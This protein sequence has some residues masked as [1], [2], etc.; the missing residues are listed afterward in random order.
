MREKTCCFT[1]HRELKEPLERLE[2]R[3][4]RTTETLIQEGYRYF[5]AGGARGFDALAA[6]VVLR[7]KERY[8]HIHLIMVLPFPEQYEYEFG[9]GNREIEE[10]HMLQAGASK[11]V[12]LQRGYSRGCYYARD[13][14]LVDQSSVCVAYQ[15]KQTGGTAYTTQYART[16]GVKVLWL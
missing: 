6:R 16:R 1:G 12:C 4:W 9:W 15:Y 5:G 3:V 11:V 8:P 10:Y 13:R 7:M 14:H 2:G